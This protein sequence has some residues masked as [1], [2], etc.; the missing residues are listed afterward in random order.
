MKKKTLLKCFAI[1]ALLLAPLQAALAQESGEEVLC[2]V[3]TQKDGTVSQFALRD[4]PIVS[5]EGDALVVNCG[6]QSLTTPMAGIAKFTFEQVV[7]DAIATVQNAQPEARIAFGN[8]SFSGMKPGAN[9]SV[10][11]IDG[12]CLHT[13]KADA[14]GHLRVSLDAFVPGVYILRTPTQSYKIKK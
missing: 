10:Y 9:V 2:M 5:Y 1:V 13:V 3:L 11:S 14:D 4:G 7:V 12:K 6:E 8:A